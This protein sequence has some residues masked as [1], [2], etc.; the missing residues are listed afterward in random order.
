M[1]SHVGRA[2]LVGVLTF[3]GGCSREPVGTI[4]VVPKADP[5]TIESVGV[6][7]LCRV[8]VDAWGGDGSCKLHVSHCKRAPTGAIGCEQRST[9]FQLACGEHRQVCGQDFR[10]SCPPDAASPVPAKGG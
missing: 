3:G 2:V 10:C 5:V 9:L 1:R 7:E 8:G 6:G 4:V